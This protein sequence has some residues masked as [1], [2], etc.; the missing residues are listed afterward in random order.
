MIRPGRVVVAGLV[1]AAAA[2][3]RV[4]TIELQA[5]PLE[6]DATP[7]AS[8]TP[9]TSPTPTSSP[10]PTPTPT[11]AGPRE[12][13]DTDRARFVAEHQEAS[14][15]ELDHVAVDLD[16]DD[17]QELLFHGVRDGRTLVE[18]AWWSGTA[19]EIGFTG[20]GGTAEQVD[21]VRPADVNADGFVEVVTFQSGSDAAASSTVWQV[22]GPSDVV[23]LVA[24]GG[25]HDGS[26]TYGVI[27]VEWRDED[28]DGVDEIVA[29]CDDSPLPRSSWTS[30]T[31]TWRDGAY[32]HVPEVVP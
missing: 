2:C 7:T 10:T 17:Q 25:C 11:T 6:D 22:R 1:L 4:P 5:E 32:R 15:V 27:G 13:T 31:Y 14:A 29:T 19:Y 20:Q 8:P 30:D 28:G 26:S 9:T 16:G 18:I 3:T 21:R 12:P 24:D 23:D